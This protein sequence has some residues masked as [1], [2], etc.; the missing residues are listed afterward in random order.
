MVFFPFFIRKPVWNI[1]LNLIVCNIFITYKFIKI[2]KGT[3]L[4]ALYESEEKYSHMIHKPKKKKQE[5]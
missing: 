2:E 1:R 3:F 5:K 4:L